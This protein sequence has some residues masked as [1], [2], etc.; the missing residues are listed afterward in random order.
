MA[1]F[2][3]KK[4]QEAMRSRLTSLA[5]LERVVARRRLF[6][7]RR[8]EELEWD[9]PLA[10]HESIRKTMDEDR[11]GQFQ[12]P[13]AA[14]GFI[15]AGKKG[16]GR[17]LW[18]QHD[19]AAVMGIDQGNVSRMI[20]RISEHESYAWLREPLER[21]SCAGKSYGVKGTLYDEGIFGVLIG[22]LQ[23]D[24]I[25]RILHPR[26]RTDV[27][28]PEDAIQIR[29]FWDRLRR[30]MDMTDV[31]ARPAAQDSAAVPSLGVVAG[32][33]N[34]VTHSEE[35]PP[36]PQMDEFLDPEDQRY[37]D[38]IAGRLY[39]DQVNMGTGETPAPLPVS[40][41]PRLASLF[42]SMVKSMGRWGGVSIAAPLSIY[43]ELS[44]LFHQVYHWF[45]VIGLLVVLACL[46]IL[47]RR[48]G[49]SPMIE[50]VGSTALLVCVIWGT[51]FVG[52]GFS[53][54]NP[55]P[56]TRIPG[57]QDL[58]DRIARLEGIEARQIA[59]A[60]AALEE[61]LNVTSAFLAERDHTD[62]PVSEAE[63]EQ[64]LDRAN[65]QETPVSL[66]AQRSALR[67][68]EARIYLSWGAGDYESGL[69]KLQTAG[70][71]LSQTEM[72]LVSLD[73]DP[74]LEGRVLLTRG[75]TICA[76]I[77]RGLW[78]EQLEDAIVA[79]ER[80]FDL[81]EKGA[82]LE[83]IRAKEVL[84]RLYRARADS[85]VDP[86]VE[87]L[88]LSAKI[89]Q[90]GLALSESNGGF[91]APELLLGMG[92]NLAAAG[93]NEG[94]IRA[95]KSALARID[96]QLKPN[97]FADASTRLADVYVMD[98]R[99]SHDPQALSNARDAFF[100]AI[101]VLGD[102]A[103]LASRASLQLSI[104]QASLAF[105]H[106]SQSTE[107][108]EQG[109]R[110]AN[111][112]IGAWTLKDWP[113]AHLQ[114]LCAR[115]E[116]LRMMALLPNASQRST[117]PAALMRQAV[118]PLD[119]IAWLDR[120]N[121]ALAERHRAPLFQAYCSLIRGR[122][123]WGTLAPREAGIH[124]AAAEKA[125]IRAR[126]LANGEGQETL[127]DIQRALNRAKRSAGV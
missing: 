73:A 56:L 67:V 61:G 80:A 33:E 81:L 92:R 10:P 124:F 6:F 22:C 57:M 91:M 107:A 87:D 127:A 42:I 35:L 120:A 69:T 126:Q 37:P 55:S 74:L 96:V 125:L 110:A 117:P 95:C 17:A 75:A 85:F 2:P 93:R 29:G 11:S 5:E 47:R 52:R 98:Y 8:Y 82:P 1:S 19:I 7:A 39:R 62:M 30:E 32:V 72:E 4:Q 18:N 64:M 103:H 59:R 89:A 43:M 44:S 23:E 118:I 76:G 51:C 97:L 15:P 26:R 71:L 60:R 70:N 79:T 84:A 112:A 116:I 13:G 49:S 12:T 119:Q 77:E 101:K 40:E 90:D 86:R 45:P 121:P 88:V 53:A 9:D 48:G 34:H 78:G 21:C 31:A 3:T 14:A 114:A 28:A 63:Y 113:V 115:S 105:A 109:L 104:A 27:P 58:Q 68:N 41:E 123:A 16:N 65:I 54:E 99:D 46:I 38:E 94:A 111:L 25:E 20:H 122:I 36:L 106:A 24:Y 108:L 100:A 66:R 50:R 83:A 102:N